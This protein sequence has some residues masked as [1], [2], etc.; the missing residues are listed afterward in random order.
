[1]RI[2]KDNIKIILILL[3][4]CLGIGYSYLNTELNINGT[5]NINSANW[6]VYWNN[7]QVTEGSVSASTPTIDSDKTTVSY[8]V[9][10][11]QPG[12][13]YEFTV[14]AVN[15]GT[16]DAMIETID[17][18]LNG[19]TMEEVPAY[20][21]YG[22]SYADDT[23]LEENQEL[24]HDSTETYKVHIGYADYIEADE[25]PDENQSLSLELTV[26]YKQADENAIPVIHSVSFAEDS[27]ETI[28]A[29]VQ[30]GNTSNYNVGD[31]KIVDMGSLGTH[32]L[33]IANKSTPTECST[34]GFSETACGFVLEFADIITTHRMNPSGEYQ[35]EQYNNGWNK[36]GWPASEMR[37]YVNSDI[38]NALPS[39]LKNG[40]INTTVVSGHGSRDSANFTSIDKLYLLATHEVWEVDDG[41]TSSGIDYNDAAYNNTRQLDYYSSQNI[42]TSS[43]SGAIKQRNGSNDYWWLRSAHSSSNYIFYDVG[44]IGSCNSYRSSNATGVSPAFRIG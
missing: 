21:D 9:T 28:V 36:D 15:A 23:P 24:L 42:T 35:G 18:K 34:T 17:S 43:Y 26:T 44:T 31:T 22:I 27:W 11:A 6:S 3:V 14:D 33:R 2:D 4:I 19:V 13:Y 32:T 39:E 10:L 40:I 38:Y 20:L 37:T 5:A 30:A 8:T 25:L 12:D 29:A 41:D 7:V 1:M 16:I